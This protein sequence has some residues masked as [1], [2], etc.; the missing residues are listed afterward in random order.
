M[1]VATDSASITAQRVLD[2][3]GRT[4]YDT[5]EA[6]ALVGLLDRPFLES[7]IRR[8]I[9]SQGSNLLMLATRGGSVERL[10]AEMMAQ[11]T[12]KERASFLGDAS[13]ERQNFARALADRWL[14]RMGSGTGWSVATQEE[15]GPDLSLC[16]CAGAE[17]APVEILV[18]HTAG[19]PRVASFDS[20]TLVAT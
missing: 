7:E 16:T 18:H 4:Y 19:G 2:I 1:T 11:G 14:R 5:I 20:R 17:A 12:A 8:W 9:A 10:V 6:G 15:L 3:V 13:E